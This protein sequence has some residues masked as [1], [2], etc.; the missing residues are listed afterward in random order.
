MK[1]RA[2]EQEKKARG[3][4]RAAAY[5]LWMV[6]DELQIAKEELQAVRGELWVVKVEYQ[7]DKEELQVARDELRLKTTTL[8]R[9][10]QEVTE[11]EST[12][13]CLNK[14]YHRLC[15]DLQRQQA[16]VSQKKGVIAELRVE[17]WT[18]WASRWL[19]FRHKASKVFPGLSFNFPI[20][21]ED[22]VGESDFDEEDVLRVSS[23]V[24]SS[25]LLPGYP[26]GEVAQ[27]PA[28]NT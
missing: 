12:V 2:E 22:E 8:S 25:T 13:R 4:L 24:P 7:V 14:E 28:F 11:A 26:M 17:A 6:K 27:V 16:L 20:P 3:K 5:K 18:L 23:T 19:A 10:C 1:L 21:V 15:D 9:V